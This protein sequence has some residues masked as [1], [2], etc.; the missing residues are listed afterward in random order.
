MLKRLSIT[1]RATIFVVAVCALLVVS[2]GWRSWN[3]RAVKL[4]EVETATNNLARAMTQQADDT[5]KSAEL[6]LAETVERVEADGVEE[7][8]ALRLHQVLVERVAQLPQLDGLFVYDDKGRWLVNSRPALQQIYNNADRDYFIYHRNHA[9]RGS[10][11][12]GRP[13]RSR[14]SGKWI[15]TVSRRINHADGSFAGVALATIDIDYFSRFYDHFDIGDHGAVVLINDDGVILVRR[16]NGEVG[17]DV[18]NTPLMRAHQGATSGNAEFTS[19]VDGVQR[20]YSYRSLEHFPLFVA[21]A[22]SRDEAL[23]QWRHDAL[24][25]TLGVLLLAGLIGFFGLRL[26]RQIELRAAAEKELLVARDALEGLNHSLEK[27]AMQDGLTGLANRRQFDVTLGNEFSRAMRAGAPLAFVMIDVD[28]F[29]QYNDRYGHTRG[30]ECLRIVSLAIRRL[31]PNRPG[32]LAARYGGEEIGIL[33]PNTSIDGA[34]AVADR[35][36][37]AIA[38]TDTEHIGSPFGHV[39]VSAGV[40]ALVPLRGVHLPSHLVEAAD[41]ALYAA[42]ACGRD[43]V[44][45]G[46]VDV[47]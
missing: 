44:H 25:H 18:S 30:D 11:Y 12:V 4:Q 37:Q 3:A 43:R 17:K 21:A 19:A 46:E 38:D 22:L 32:D 24:L 16:P 9:G 10:S 14:S 13:V 40:A 15:I 5:L 39:T 33:L 31:T 35:I 8:A 26:V 20:V 2:D 7:D 1:G 34:L 23:Q 28:H 27:L 41:R 47:A 45:S 42:K 29:K 6:A 36:R